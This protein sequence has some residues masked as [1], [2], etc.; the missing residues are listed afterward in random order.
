MSAPTIPTH[1]LHGSPF[2]RGH[3]HGSACAAEIRHALSRSKAAW[4]RDA[5]D[6]ARG[7][8]KQSWALLED[9]APQIVQELQGMAKGSSCDVMELYL[10]IGFEFF[11]MPS[12]TGCSGIAIAAPGGAI[13]GQNWDAPT[14]DAREL[15]L[16]LHV[17][18]Q[19]VER[20]FIASVGT[21][22][23][24]GC[25][26]HGLAL[27]TNDLML[28]AIPHGLPS[29]VVRRLVLDQ[30]TVSAAVATLRSLPNM[31]GRCYLLG[32]A[33]GAVAGVE[34]SPSVGVR[35]MAT[36]SPILHT[37]HARLL[38]TAAI[39]DEARLQAIYPSTRHRLDALSRVSDG[40]RTVTD[41]K[42]ILRNR[43]GAPNA[44]SKSL[45]E[46]E[47]TETAFSIIFECAAGKLHLCAGPPS[48]GAYAPFSL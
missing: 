14:E 30:P 40:A 12:P 29:Q 4:S 23:W 25:N 36:A 34:I 19:G 13:I 32:D 8:A 6:T 7:R 45:S 9:R 20:A 3:Q 33:T 31:A 37:N 21:L 22:G 48:A 17:S 28:D 46:E 27:L 10:R 39:E 38:E 15:A 44:I 47:E 26:R 43:D 41:V 24:V 2:E 5:Y 11:S 42:R 18:E 16:F 35:E 1:I